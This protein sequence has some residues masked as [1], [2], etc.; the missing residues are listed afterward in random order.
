M[1]ANKFVPYHH[2]GQ[3]YVVPAADVKSLNK[4]E[5][6]KGFAWGP[7]YKN[8]RLAEAACSPDTGRIELTSAEKSQIIAA[9]KSK[10]GK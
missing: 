7:A 4:G 8:Q 5:E 10:W 1:G 6:P 3:W 9:K 2:N